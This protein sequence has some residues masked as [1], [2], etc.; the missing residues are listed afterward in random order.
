MAARL[1]PA[2]QGPGRM[3]HVVHDFDLVI[4]V[5]ADG[6][7]TETAQQS[8]ELLA[9]AAKGFDLIGPM[10]EEDHRLIHAA[11]PFTG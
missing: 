9:I 2:A 8:R 5:H 4:H 3:R 10:C 1:L 6:S 7:P 11:G